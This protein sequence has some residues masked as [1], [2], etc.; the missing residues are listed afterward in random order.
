[1]R[2][3]VAYYRAMLH[4]A[5]LWDCMSSVRLCDCWNTSKII[6]RPNSLGSLLS[7]PPT[8]ALWC[9][10]NTTKMGW[11]QMKLIKPRFSLLPS[12]WRR[13]AAINRCHARMESHFTISSTRPTYHE[14]E[15]M[16]IMISFFL[17]DAMHSAVL[18][19]YSICLSVC[20]SVTH[21]RYRYRAHV[22]L[23]FFENN[24]TAEYLKAYALADPTWAIW[25]NANTPKLR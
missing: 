11:G 20:L 17:R 9:N 10:E 16:I 6:A 5:R 21:F 3:C 19:Q 15:F 8:G 4:K 2:I 13:G 7:L 25:C 24:F 1:M 22:G 12:L 14:F 23:E 18:A